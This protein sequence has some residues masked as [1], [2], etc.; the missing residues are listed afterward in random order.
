MTPMPKQ[1]SLLSS[2]PLTPFEE[3]LLAMLTTLSESELEPKS[4]ITVI[5]TEHGEVA[6]HY[7]NATMQDMMVAKGFIDLDIQSDAILGNLPFYV[8]Q[9]EEEGL[10][11]ED[12]CYDDT[13]E[14]DDDDEQPS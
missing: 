8:R 12:Y 1:Y 5:L 9:A 2:E 11:D 4:A 7:Y 13:E 10:L 3:E 6:T 14:E